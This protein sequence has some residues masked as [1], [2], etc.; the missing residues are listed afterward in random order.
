M[1]TFVWGRVVAHELAAAGR[2]RAFA[3]AAAQPAAEGVCA[4]L[5]LSHLLVAPHAPR[6]GHKLEPR[7]SAGVAVG[8]EARAPRVRKSGGDWR[9]GGAAER[10]DRVELTIA[11]HGAQGA[12]CT[13]AVR[14]KAMLG[15]NG[16]FALLGNRGRAWPRGA[17]GC[18]EH[19]AAVLEHSKHGARA[20]QEP[21]NCR[22]QP[23]QVSRTPPRQREAAHDSSGCTSHTPPAHQRASSTGAWA[24]RDCRWRDL[25]SNARAV[26]SG[27]TT[28][29]YPCQRQAHS[30]GD[31]ASR[32]AASVAKVRVVVVVLIVVV[33]VVS[34]GTLRQHAAERAI[35]AVT[36][37]L[38]LRALPCAQ[39]TAKDDGPHLLLLQLVEAARTSCSVHE[40]LKGAN[41]VDA[42]RGCATD[43]ALEGGEVGLRDGCAIGR[44]EAAQ[45]VEAAVH[46]DGAATFTRSGGQCRRCAGEASNGLQSRNA[47]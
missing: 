24:C 37:R 3:L 39:A 32:T 36:R 20:S 13:H 27:A 4:R 21:S 14:L 42:G 10:A 19:A 15:R 41:A 17:R 44:R 31:S 9:G 18:D 34:V 1:R 26:R 35:G 7:V 38:V 46:S 11:L 23:S 5:N 30:D 29:L 28:R 33:V 6:C 47:C 45:G 40:R 25:H 8:S 43:A 22:M 16:K 2:C 12:C